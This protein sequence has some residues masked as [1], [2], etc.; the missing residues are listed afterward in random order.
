MNIPHTN[1]KKAHFVK[2]EDHYVDPQKVEA[3]Y[4]WNGG[5]VI[6]MDSGYEFKV[7]VHGSMK[8]NIK[9]IATQLEGG[10]E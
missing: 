10:A 9:R 6:R 7:R 3:V 5:I 2:I 4:P 8:D 1:I